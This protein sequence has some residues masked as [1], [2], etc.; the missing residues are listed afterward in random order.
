MKIE[1]IYL[2]ISGNQEVFAGHSKRFAKTYVEFPGDYEHELVVALCNGATED[3]SHV[4]IFSGIQCRFE[5]YNGAP[6]DIPA[7]QHFVRLSSADIIVCMSSLVHFKKRGWL[8]RLAEEIRMNGEGLYGAMS[9]FEISPHIRT[10]FYACSPESYRAYPHDVGTRGESLAFESGF[11]SEKPSISKWFSERSKCMVVCWDGCYPLSKSRA[12]ENVF[13]KGDQ[14]N[15]IAFD[16]HTEIYENESPSERLILEER[17]NPH[18]RI[19][20]I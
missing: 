13:R 4:D 18:E 10:C 20:T 19:P 5:Y 15:C 14:S 9:S 2:H 8:K 11:G 12:P 1:L 7:Q 3:R 17:T 6:F 16:R